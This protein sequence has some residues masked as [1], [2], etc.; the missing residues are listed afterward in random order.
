MDVV[1]FDI[2]GT[3]IHSAGA[4]RSALDRALSQEFG[5]P[6][7]AAIELHG[8]TDRG[9]ARNIFRQFAIEETEENWNRFR[10]AYLAAL[11]ECLAEWP[12]TVLPGVFELLEHLAARPGTAIGLLTGNVRE[13]AR[14]K[15]GHYGVEVPFDIG[16][17]GDRHHERDDVAREAWAAVRQELGERVRADRVWVIGDTPHDVTCARAINAKVV[18]VCTGGFSVTELASSQPDF[19]VDDLTQVEPLLAALDA[20]AA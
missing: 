2:D 18:A 16:G 12:G 1:L 17:F 11:P 15:L 9:I 13:G 7:T 19:L 4:G 8:R 20:T 3:L 5:H 14:L 10:T 6:S